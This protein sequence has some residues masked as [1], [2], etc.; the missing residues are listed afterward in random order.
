M[1][2]TLKS[3]RLASVQN[4]DP[5]DELCSLT[6][7]LVLKLRQNL[8]DADDYFTEDLE[9]LGY[10]EE[11]RIELLDVLKLAKRIRKKTLALKSANRT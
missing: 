3:K 4:A 7:E 9:F 1:T 8:S 10:A 2:V 5:H 6:N 11:K